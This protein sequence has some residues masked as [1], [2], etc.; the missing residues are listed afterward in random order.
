M[1]EVSIKRNKFGGNSN[2]QSIRGFDMMVAL[3]LL[4]GIPL[5]YVW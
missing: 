3:I 4:L 2:R 1:K 5:L